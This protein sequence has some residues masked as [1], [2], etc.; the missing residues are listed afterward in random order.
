MIGRSTVIQM[1]S[2]MSVPIIF[3]LYFT[4]VNAFFFLKKHS[5]ST[6][7]LRA[8]DITWGVPSFFPF[9]T[10]T[11]WGR[12]DQEVTTWPELTTARMAI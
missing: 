9:E 6:F 1:Q 10:T 12:S 4:R 7:S 8:P 11:L 2:G 5:C 3:H